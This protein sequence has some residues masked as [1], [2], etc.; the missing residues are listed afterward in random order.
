MPL[1]VVRRPGR[2]GW[3]IVGTITPAG[4]R[5]GVRIRRRA[6]SDKEGIAREE[7]A[8]LEAKVLRD[9]HHGERPAA[10]SWNDAV[11]AYIRHESRSE[12]TLALIDKL[13]GHFGETALDRIGQDEVARA[14]SCF[15]PAPSRAPS[16]AT[17]SCRYER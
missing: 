11:K 7:A 15:G 14:K 9:F 8:A 2:D 5:K 3:W 1:E 17:S 6:G 10:R 12:G 4:A 13:T 16:C